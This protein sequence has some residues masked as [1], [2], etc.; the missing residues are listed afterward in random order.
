VAWHPEIGADAVKA[1][2][3]VNAECVDWNSVKEWTRKHT[4]SPK[5]GLIT[6]PDGMYY[7]SLN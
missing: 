3:T 7:F 4:F 5:E 2:N 1:N 6:Q